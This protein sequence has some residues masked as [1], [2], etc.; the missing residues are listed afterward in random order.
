MIEGKEQSWLGTAARLRL[1][2][3]LERE[4]FVGHVNYINHSE[5]ETVSFD[6]CTYI[7]T[8]GPFCRIMELLDLVCSPRLRVL[9]RRIIKARQDAFRVSDWEKHAFLI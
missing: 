2:E 8:I 7:L 5:S 9:R 6:D 1:W 3:M 4:L